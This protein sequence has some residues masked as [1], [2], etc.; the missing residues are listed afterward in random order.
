[1]E[2]T[3]DASALCDPATG[4]SLNY[5][6]L[7]GRAGALAA[8][9]ASEK[10]GKG[11]VVAVDLG[12]SVEL[13]VA[14]LGILRAGAAYLPIDGHAPA[15]RV[16]G[17]LDEAD[18]RVVVGGP[19]DS[20]VPAALRR[21]AV[22]GRGEGVR[23]SRRRSRRPRVRRVH[24]R[25]DRTAQGRRRAAPGGRP[26]GHGRRSSAR[27]SPGTAC[28]NCSNPAFDATTFEVWSPLTVG[29]AVVVV[30]LG[31]PTS[32]STTGWTW[33]APSAIDA[34][35]LTT[36][37]FH[38]IAR[39]R[40]EAFAHAVDPGHR[41]RAARADAVREG[42]GRRTAT[43]DRQRVRPDRDHDVRRVLRVH[44]A[45]ACDGLDRTPIGFP[46]QNTHAAR[47]GRRPEAGAA[48]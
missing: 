41:R 3:P 44:D 39:E 27:S 4:E 9:L 28:A 30:P 19:A 12:R 5:A 36:S 14:L 13:V 11:D 32:P 22:P 45:R 42:A 17:I 10:V 33:S 25:L 37:L 29:G 31:R 8:A 15:D 23:R 38:T 16:E 34:M 35:F 20:R 2:R 7:W 26:A 43:P 21:I 6:E 48:G 18:V 47:A 46:L 40:P 24:L 1:M